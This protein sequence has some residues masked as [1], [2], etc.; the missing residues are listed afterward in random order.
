MVNMEQRQVILRGM[1]W[2]V[3]WGGQRGSL[4]KK[5][6]KQ[7]QQMRQEY[8]TLFCFIAGALW[9]VLNYLCV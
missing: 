6:E 7:R 2:G 9:L 3:G 5:K 1:L 8:T 4:M